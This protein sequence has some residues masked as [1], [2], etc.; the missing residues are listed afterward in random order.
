MVRKLARLQH[1]LLAA[2]RHERHRHLFWNLI[3]L[4]LVTLK[5]L[6]IELSH[7]YNIFLA[8]ALH[9]L[10]KATHLLL[11]FQIHLIYLYFILIT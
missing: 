3:L 1:C 2:C 8:C 6:L 4:G 9:R 11:V 7:W 10:G 5:V